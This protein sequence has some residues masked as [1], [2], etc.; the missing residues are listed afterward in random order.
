MSDETLDKLTEEVV[1]E[2]LGIHLSTERSL[3]LPLLLR[4]LEKWADARD[5]INRTKP[6][7]EKG[8]LD[9][10]E[11]R[12]AIRHLTEMRTSLLE[13]AERAKD[14]VEDVTLAEIADGILEEWGEKKPPPTKNS[15]LIIEGDFVEWDEDPFRYKGRGTI[16]RIFD[17]VRSVTMV[18]IRRGDM[19]I[20]T[21]PASILRVVRRVS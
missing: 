17:S 4:R 21:I 3:P 16:I 1:K 13:I 15:P 20:S 12:E 10:T 19:Q 5:G 7:R 18:D 2:R 11:L 6:H 14:N 8:P 9:S